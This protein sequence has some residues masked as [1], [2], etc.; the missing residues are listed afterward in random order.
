MLIRQFPG[1]RYSIP[2]SIP[3]TLNGQMAKNKSKRII[4]HR[5][6][7]RRESA[8]GSENPR[9]NGGAFYLRYMV[10]TENVSLDLIMPIRFVPSAV[11]EVQGVRSMTRS[12]DSALSGLMNTRMLLP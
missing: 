9:P 10:Q 6:Y 1:E 7:Y 2:I 5:S 11:Q 4:R 8:V 12:T 3:Y